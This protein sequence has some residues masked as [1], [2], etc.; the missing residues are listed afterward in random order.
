M[1]LIVDA[2]PIISILISPG[3]PVDILF[4]EELELF[5]PELLF[6]ELNNNKQLIIQKSKLSEEEI[7]EFISILKQIIT[8]IPEEDFIRYRKFAER[9]CPDDKD[10]VY[11]ALALH[12]K[13]PIWSNEKRLKNQRY[14]RVHATHDLI[15]LFNLNV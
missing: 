10:I 4:L 3:K 1:Q 15:S 7:N 8:I 2:N 12:L 9:I 14:V 6:E 5:A 11:F 13:C